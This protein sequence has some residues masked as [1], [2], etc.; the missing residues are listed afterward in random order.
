MLIHAVYDFIA[1]VYLVRKG[2][3]VET[4]LEIQDDGID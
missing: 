1:L 2:R 3:R 4:G